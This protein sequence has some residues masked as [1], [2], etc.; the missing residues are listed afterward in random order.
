M[1]QSL[2]NQYSFELLHSPIAVTAMGTTFST[3]HQVSWHQHSAAQFLYASDGIIRVLTEHGCWVAPPL[4]AVWIPANTTHQLEIVSTSSVK[5]LII[6]HDNN[7]QSLP[8]QCKVISVSPL[9]KEIM[10][11]LH[12]KYWPI[13]LLENK[14][15]IDVFIDQMQAMSVEPLLYP[16][17]QHP[18]IKRILQCFMDTPE[19]NTSIEA[20]ANMFHMSVRTLSRLFIKE[21]NMG[22]RQCRQQ[23]RLVMAIERLAK[24]QSVINISYELGF[25][26]ESNFI[27]VFKAAF[28]VTPKQYFKVPT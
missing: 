3:G 15:L 23:I 13:D 25:S 22:F 26:N 9:L 4:R 24:N 8:Q 18:K 21:M 6:S 12:S 17:S 28:G 20:W 27:K 5:S 10:L 14:R 19:D 16:E 7:A 1:T 2:I 11:H